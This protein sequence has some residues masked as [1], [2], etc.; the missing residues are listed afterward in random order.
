MRHPFPGPGLGVRI[1]GEI[2]A[3]YADTLRRADAIFIDALRREGY[4]DKVSQAFAVFLPVRSVGVVGDARVAMRTSSHCVR[5]KR[6][7]S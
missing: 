4:Y 6:Q 1:L 7:T 3:E 5:W 2:N